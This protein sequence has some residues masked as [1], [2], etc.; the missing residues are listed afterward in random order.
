MIKIGVMINPPTPNI[1]RETIIE[2][3]I[4]NGETPNESPAIFGSLKGW[5]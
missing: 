3:S 4:M 2:E 5:K 1:E